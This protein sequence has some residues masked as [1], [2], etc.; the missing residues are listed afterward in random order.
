MQSNEIKFWW[1]G[2]ENR[3]K[4]SQKDLESSKKSIGTYEK[5]LQ[6]LEAELN[7]VAV[8]TLY[9]SDQ[10]NNQLSFQCVCVCVFFLHP[11]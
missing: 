6:E 5:K 10:I 8:S 2:L 1:Q 7:G 3:L 4:Y 9:L 11:K